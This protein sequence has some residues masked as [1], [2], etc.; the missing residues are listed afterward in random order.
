MGRRSARAGA[1]AQPGPGPRAAK[2]AGL[3]LAVTGLI[4]L[5]AERREAAKAQSAL[6]ERLPVVGSASRQPCEQCLVHH[7][8]ALEVHEVARLGDDNH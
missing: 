2:R 7:V 1:R 3:H 5:Y 4:A 8:R 6:A